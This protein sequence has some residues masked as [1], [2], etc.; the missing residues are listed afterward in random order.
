MTAIAAPSSRFD[1]LVHALRAVLE[2]RCIEGA[3]FAWKKNARG[4]FVFALLVPLGALTAAPTLREDLRRDV[5]TVR[6]ERGLI[7][8][9]VRWTVT[10]DARA[11]LALICAPH[12]FAESKRALYAIERDLETDRKLK[13]LA[14]LRR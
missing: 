13:R 9:R 12:Y 5:V 8:A 10:K 1:V 4:D 2:R 7:D 14:R 6:R 3:L 11:A